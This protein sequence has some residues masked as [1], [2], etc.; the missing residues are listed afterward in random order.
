MSE[1]Q[2]A[3]AAEMP[4]NILAQYIRDVSFENPNAPNSLRFADGAPEMDVNIGLDARKIE[5]D[6][7]IYEVVLSVRAEAL[8]KDEPVFICELHY[9]ITVEIDQSVP[10]DRHHPLLFIEM[11][12]QVFPYVRQIVSNLVANGGFPPLYL[13]PVDFHQLYLQRFGDEIKAAKEKV[14]V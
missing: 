13:A 11:P 12:R 4:V 14:G 8:Q 7:F 10:E 6:S 5:K 3:S 1:D 9:G 2:Q